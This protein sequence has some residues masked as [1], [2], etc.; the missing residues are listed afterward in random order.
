MSL[1]HPI[2]TEDNTCVIQLTDVTDLVSGTWEGESGFFEKEMDLT[3]HENVTGVEVAVSDDGGVVSGQDTLATCT[4]Q[5]GRPTP[6]V[7]FMLMEGVEE[8]EVG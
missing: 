2:Q 6:E 1:L 3:I 8:V 5:G 4:V 7:V